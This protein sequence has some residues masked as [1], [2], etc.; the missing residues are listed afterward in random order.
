M[1]PVVSCGGE[2]VGH[3]GQLIAISAGASRRDI[4]ADIRGN[5]E[6]RLQNKI[7]I[8]HNLNNPSIDAIHTCVRACVRGHTWLS[9]LDMA[10][11]NSKPHALCVEGNPT[12]LGP[13][14]NAAFRTAAQAELIFSPTG[15]GS[16]DAVQNISTSGQPSAISDNVPCRDMT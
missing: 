3:I 11:N 15:G 1:W 9:A 10:T 12:Y 14:P 2:Q 7:Q 8:N 5:G 6:G 13:L 4:R 16:L